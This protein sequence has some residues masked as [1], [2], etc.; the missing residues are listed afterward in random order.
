MVRLRTTDSLRFANL[1][2]LVGK[3]YFD[4][5]DAYP[6]GSGREHRRHQLAAALRPHVSA[7]PPSRLLALLG[8]ALKWQQHQGQLPAGQKFNLFAGGAVLRVV[9]PETYVSAPGP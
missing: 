5:R 7:V 3:P 4:A 1:E 9:E 2:G 8:Q 6:G